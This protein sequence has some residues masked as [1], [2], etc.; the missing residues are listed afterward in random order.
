MNTT[1]HYIYVVVYV[2][3][4]VHGT[5]IIISSTVIETGTLMVKGYNEMH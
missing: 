3:D 2:N 5:F 4:N 1:E